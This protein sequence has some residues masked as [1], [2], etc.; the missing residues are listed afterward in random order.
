M[1]ISIH[2]LLTPTHTCSHLGIF[3]THLT[4]AVACSMCVWCLIDASTTLGYKIH[5]LAVKAMFASSLNKLFMQRIKK[6]SS[7]FNQIIIIFVLWIFVRLEM[8][9]TELVWTCLSNSSEHNQKQQTSKWRNENCHNAFWWY[10]KI[11]ER[12]LVIIS[13]LCISFKGIRICFLS[14][15]HRT[16]SIIEWKLTSILFTF[17]TNH[18]ERNASQ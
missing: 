14:F 5:C 15:I 1:I 3:A 16:N 13:F 9:W 7:S 10:V 17:Y 12:R 11:E 2:F 18:V 8:R 6:T 4:V